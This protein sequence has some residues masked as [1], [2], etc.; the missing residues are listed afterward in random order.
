MN[1]YSKVRTNS[2]FHI[3]G[4]VVALRTAE[5]R[6]MKLNLSATA[7]VNRDQQ[8]RQRVQKVK[9]V[10]YRGRFGTWKACFCLFINLA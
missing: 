5:I 9:V 10:R 1:E 2:A 4:S 6:P 8:R 3:G 7:E